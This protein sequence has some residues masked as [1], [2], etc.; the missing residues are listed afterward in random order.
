MLPV[1]FRAELEQF[2]WV[3]ATWT[4][5]KLIAASPFRYERHPS[6]AVIFEHGGWRDYGA[7]DPEWASGNFVKLLAF[8]RDE[9]Y[10]ETRD[11]LAAKYGDIPADGDDITL[12]LPKLGGARPKL[13]RIDAALLGRYLYRHLYLGGRGISEDVQRLMRIGYDRERQAVTIPWFN[14]DGTL[15]NVKYRSVN[16]KA[17]WYESGARPIREMLYGIDIAYSRRIKRAAIVEAEIDALTL[18]SAGIFAIATGGTAFNAAKRD[19]LLRSPIEEVTLFRDNDNAGRTWRNRVVAE[20]RGKIDVSIALVPT[21]YKDVND[22]RR[23]DEI[24][25]AYEGRRRLK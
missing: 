25:R 22:W 4:D 13:R 14:A 16:S 2:T 1:D 12:R 11:Y 23:P 6:F 18:M 19:L 20:L 15:G 21:R 8:L 7:V 9:T 24:R 10:E 5:E 17:F 3:N